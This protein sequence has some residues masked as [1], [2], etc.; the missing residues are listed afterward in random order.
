MLRINVT[1]PGQNT[2]THIYDTPSTVLIGRAP[3]CGCRIEHDPLVSR[4]HA[5]LSIHED[6][7]AIRNLESLNG[8]IINGVHYGGPS[9]RQLQHPKQLHD[10]DTVVV[11]ETILTISIA[12]ARPA[13][14]DDSTND[15]K[16]HPAKRR[17]TSPVRRA[18]AIPGYIIESIIGSGGMGVVYQARKL[19][20]GH[21][22]AIKTMHSDIAGSKHALRN[23]HHEIEVTRHIFHPNIIGYVDSGVTSDSLL[24]LVLE[25]AGGGDL[26]R[27]L[28]KEGGRFEPSQV[29]SF[30]VQI[31][32]GLSH[33]HHLGIVHRDIKPKNLF[34]TDDVSQTIK[35]GDLGLASQEDETNAPKSGSGGGTVAYMPP[36]Q[37]NKTRSI[38]PACDVFSVG[39]TLYEMLCGKRPYDFSRCDK[40]E[41]VS[42]GMVRPL[43][44]LGIPVY[45][46]LRDIVD[47][48]IAPNPDD[49]FRDCGELFL[50]LHNIR[51]Q[52]E[53]SRPLQPENVV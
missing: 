36:E 51:M 11:G 27:R 34:L 2:R 35:I 24:Y 1:G 39:A 6:R 5:V 52:H 47:K 21:K 17:R 38:G 32:S 50:A 46:G 31:A 49:R 14:A 28:C 22:V 42:R 40:R 18:S 25:F 15:K 48:C 23:F 10:G 43:A 13:R 30:A 44:Q 16:R 26:A 53:T 12:L 3:L 19:S 4:C 9:S 20:T 45:S 7:V 8:L 41:A 33:M 29:H 37:L